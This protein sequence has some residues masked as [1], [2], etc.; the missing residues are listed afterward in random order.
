[1][2][3]IGIAVDK[4]QLLSGAATERHEHVQVDAVDAEIAASR[5]SSP[6]TTPAP[7]PPPLDR[8]DRLA[9]LQRLA[10]LRR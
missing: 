1:M 5:P 2:T 6:P 9:K 4:T 3:A 10:Y 7:R 8:H